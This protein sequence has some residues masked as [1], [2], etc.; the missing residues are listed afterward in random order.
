[1]RTDEID[2]IDPEQMNPKKSW[3]EVFCGRYC[4]GGMDE[5]EPNTQGGSDDPRGIECG[6]Q[7]TTISFVIDRHDTIFER[8]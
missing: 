6:R 5:E 2:G 1:M 3:F 4:D 8:T 7:V